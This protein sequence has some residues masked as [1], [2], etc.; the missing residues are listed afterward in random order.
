MLFAHT[1][2]QPARAIA[3]KQ[4]VVGDH[5]EIEFETIEDEG[6]LELIST[7]EIEPYEFE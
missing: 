6:A 1:S 3:T 4:D 5:K 7:E 2:A